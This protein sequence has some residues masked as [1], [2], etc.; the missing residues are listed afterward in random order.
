MQVAARGG[1]AG[2]G[3]GPL[4]LAERGGQLVKPGDGD[5]E[6]EIVQRLGDRGDGAMRRRGVSASASGPGA[7][8]S[9]TGSRAIACA[10][11]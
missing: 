8:S 5:V 4:G 11:R 3:A 7:A 2:L 1:Q 10:R 9:G 6:G